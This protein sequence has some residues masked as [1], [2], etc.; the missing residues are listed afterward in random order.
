MSSSL[1]DNVAFEYGADPGLDKKFISGLH[2]A[3]FIPENERCEMGL[4]TE[5]GERGVNL[6]G[7]QRQR[8]NLARAHLNSRNIVL[9]DDSLSALDVHTESRICEEL[10]L[11]EWKDCTRI[12]ATHRH[13]I[14]P[15][16]SGIIFL[17][18]GTIAGMGPYSSLLRENEQFLAFIESAK[19]EG[20]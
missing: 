20:A 9:M 3:Q 11:G 2:K 10:I 6:S 12:V 7:G 4:N 1:R 17:V 19:G 8:I 5:L 15:F 14:L 16:C 13:S 18:N